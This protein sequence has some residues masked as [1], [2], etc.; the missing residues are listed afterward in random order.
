MKE[1]Q[2]VNVQGYYGLWSAIDKYKKFN[3]IT[4]YLLENNKYGDETCYLVVRED[5]FLIGETYDDIE[6]SLEDY[7]II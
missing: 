4:Y 6:T 3:D 1:F 2:N 5:G 7:S